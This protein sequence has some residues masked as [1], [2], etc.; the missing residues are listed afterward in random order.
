MAGVLLEGAE[1]LKIIGLKS[2]HLH[3]H[4]KRS[5]FGPFIFNL[6]TLSLFVFQHIVLHPSQNWMYIVQARF[7]ITIHQRIF[8][9]RRSLQKEAML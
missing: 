6:M 2:T 8:T 9:K 3:R 7:W 5:F 1:D 4:K